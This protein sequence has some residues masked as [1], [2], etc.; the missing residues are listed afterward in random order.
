MNEKLK[1]QE[2]IMGTMKISKLLFRMS[3]PLMISMMVQAFYNVVDSVFVS[4]INENA[5]TALTL[6]FP[7][8]QLMA[9][10]AGGTSVGMNYLL[11]KSIG[12]KNEKNINLAATNGFFLAIITSLIFAVFGLFFGETFARFQSSD[13]QIIAY[14]VDYLRVVTIF[15]IALFVQQIVERLLLSTGKTVH[16]M[17]IQII[18]A[19]TNIILNPIL[20]FG[21]FGFPRLEVLGA[22]IATVIGQTLACLVGIYFNMKKNDEIKISFQNFKPSLKVIKTIYSIGFPSIV[23]Q[24]I[25]SFVTYVMNTIL[26]GFTSTAVSVYGVY[27]RLQGFVWMPVFGINNSIVSI[28]AYN[29]GAKNRKRIIDTIKLSLSVAFVLNFLGFIVFQIMPETLLALFGA[30]GQMLEIGISALRI[31]SF[32]FIFSGIG[33]VSASVFQALGN[34]KLSAINSISRQLVFTVPLAYIL[35]N[36]YGLN[37]I[38]IAIPIGEVSSIILSS[39]FLVYI[40]KT[41]VNKIGE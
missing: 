38:W 9:G 18:G 11:S 25:G 35:S 29:F 34:G 20:I 32:S 2:N 15:S 41:K 14:T 12:E 39:I 7:I 21:L 10:F 26:I 19:V 24:T 37:G 13:P 3:V 5:L 31:V 22:A 1:P 17:I 8:Q 28:I 40:M 6:V 36:I 16:C 30:S 27:I 4:H 33:I 23:M